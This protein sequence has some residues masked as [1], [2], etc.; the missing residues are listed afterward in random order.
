M[1]SFVGS[2]KN[3]GR[4]LLDSHG[5]LRAS[6]PSEVWWTKAGALVGLVPGFIFGGVGIAALG[7]AFGLPWFVI[8]P[9]IGA[10]IGNR[11]GLERDRTRAEAAR[12]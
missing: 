11:I 10:V 6:R 12:R 9:L 7:T 1:G 8:G 5:R 3:V 4:L 2:A